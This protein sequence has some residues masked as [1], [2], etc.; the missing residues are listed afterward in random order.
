MH[1]NSHASLKPGSTLLSV[2]LSV[3]WRL[4]VRRN[5][6]LD[7]D[8]LPDALVASQPAAMTMI[9]TKTNTKILPNAPEG[10]RNISY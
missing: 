5:L 6:S 3:F 1:L 4:L 8:T 9:M 7:L 2:S 10:T